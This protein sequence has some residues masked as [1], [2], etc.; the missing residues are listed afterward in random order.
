MESDESAFLHLLTSMA[1]WKPWSCQYLGTTPAVDQTASVSPPPSSFPSFLP[2][3]FLLL[4]STLPSHILLF[5]S[6]L[7]VDFSLFLCANN[8]TIEQQALYWITPSWKINHLL[9]LCQAE[10]RSFI[11]EPRTEK[12]CYRT[13]QSIWGSRRF[14]GYSWE[15]FFKLRASSKIN[16]KAESRGEGLYSNSWLKRV[17]MKK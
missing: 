16:N 5:S 9:S 7:T 3:F 6:P 17:I 13:E 1:P 4:N 12:P 2:P 10:Q 11:T 14:W 8:I 15:N